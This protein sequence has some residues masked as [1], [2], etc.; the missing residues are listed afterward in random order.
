MSKIINLTPHAINLYKNGEFIET[1]P[2][3]GIVRVKF[4]NKVVDTVNGYE[5]KQ[6]K[7]IEMCDLPPQIS[8]TYYIVSRIVAEVAKRSDLLVPCDTIRD[9]EGC[10]IGCSSFAT[11]YRE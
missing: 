11:F 5:V 3:C 10:I 8:N 4:E 1:L 7:L 2:S 6:L 9:S